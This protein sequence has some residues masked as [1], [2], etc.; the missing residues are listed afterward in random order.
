[1]RPVHGVVADV[2]GEHDGQD[3]E[4]GVAGIQQREGHQGHEDAEDPAEEVGAA[5]A[6]PIRDPAP[7]RHGDQAQRGGDED[8]LQPGFAAGP[9]LGQ[10]GEDEDGVDV[11]ERVLGQ[12]QT[13][14]QGA[15]AGVGA[16]GLEHAAAGDLARPGDPLEGLAV[17]DLQADDESDGD[18]QDAG[19]E[20]DPP[21]PG[22][23]GGLG[24]GRF[25]DQQDAGGQEHAGA[26]TD[27]G[28]AAGQ[29]AFARGRV[30]DG[31]Q[32]G[33]GPFGPVAHALQDAQ[34]EQ[35]GGGDPAGGVVGGQQADGGGRQ[36][37]EQQGGDQDG[38]AADP[39]AV[40]PAEDAADGAGDEP[41]GVGG[42]GGHGADQRVGGGEEQRAED[43]GRGQSVEHEVVAL[44]G[45]ADEAGDRDARSHPR[46]RCC[47]RG[48]GGGG[49]HVWSSSGYGEE[50][51][52]CPAARRRAAGT[53]GKP[54]H[55][56][57]QEHQPRGV[58]AAAS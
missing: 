29:P 34:Q 53:G 47:R 38:L 14:G 45:G 12:P 32:G 6:D 51:T 11:V 27:L 26:R 1:L 39:V 24:Q 57:W 17:L 22:E 2:H 30:F 52:T 31:H 20:R 21:S 16:Q 54:L 4:H 5:A 58:V 33:T 55:R 50:P 28:G 3:D 25:D 8:G 7:E 42:E 46:W 44:D 13:G 40:V 56:S 41:D 15:L 49:V 19:H 18:Q 10:V 35:Q 43:G 36:P 23:V 9:A 48:G 37:G